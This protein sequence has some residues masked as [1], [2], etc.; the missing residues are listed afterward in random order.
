M[1]LSPLSSG[2]PILLTSVNMSLRRPRGFLDVI[3]QQAIALSTIVINIKLH[4]TTCW[5]IGL[6]KS[7]LELWS[8]FQ[9]PSPGIIQSISRSPQ[10]HL[11]LSV[12]MSACKAAMALL[13]YQVLGIDKPSGLT[14]LSKQELFT[15]HTRLD[16]HA[17]LQWHSTH[18]L[19]KHTCA[20]VCK[21]WGH[22]CCSL[23]VWSLS[24]SPI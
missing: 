1:L 13:W 20:V 15:S 7:S 4:K 10:Q 6:T 16:K 18:T 9:D 21:A 8:E 24:C 14:L 19:A 5:C 17:G 22:A 12:H 3:P 23:I 11:T 2:P